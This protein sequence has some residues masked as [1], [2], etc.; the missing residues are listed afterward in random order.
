[1]NTEDFTESLLIGAFIVWQSIALAIHLFSV[2]T[3]Y[4]Q[5]K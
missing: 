1:M 3:G 2:D 4:C 5:F